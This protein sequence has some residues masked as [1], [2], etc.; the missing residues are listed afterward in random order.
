MPRSKTV[1]E[2]PKDAIGSTKLPL[3]LWPA[4]A[5]ML[6]SL[7]MLDGALKYGRNNFRASAI[8]YS[9]YLDATRRHLDALQEGEDIDPDSGLPHL[10]HAL[11]TMGIV[12][13]AMMAGT[14]VDDRN[15]NGE[16]YRELVRELTP[17]VARLQ[18]M[19][20]DKDPKHFTIKDNA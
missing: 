15:F 19:H 12:A 11:A 20:A 1:A 3:H 4:A 6:G 9:V 10:A 5:S 18:A 16:R 13:D 14:L 7:G 17:H 8:R 2:N